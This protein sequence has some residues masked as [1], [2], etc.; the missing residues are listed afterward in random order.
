MKHELF[1]ETQELFNQA[2]GNSG[3]VTSI[4]PGVAS[5]VEGGG[6]VAFNHK[7]VNLLVVYDVD[8]ISEPTKIYH[9]SNVKTNLL[10]IVVDKTSIK[11]TSVTNTY[12]FTRTGKHRILFR[13]TSLS[14]IPVSAFTSCSTIISF[15]LPKQTTKIQNYAFSG[16]IKIG[17]NLKIQDFVTNIGQYAFNSCT[18]IRK[19]DVPC[20]STTIENRGFYQCRYLHEVFV[21]TDVLAGVFSRT[22]DGFG[23]LHV[24]GSLT[25][26]VGSATDNV[27][28]D[29]NKIIID[30]DLSNAGSYHYSTSDNMEVLKVGGNYSHTAGNPPFLYTY[31]QAQYRDG[32][33]HLTFIEVMGTI[34]GLVNPNYNG[35]STIGANWILH[36]GY[37]G[38]AGTPNDA[39]VTGG[40]GRRLYKVYVGDGSSEEHDQEIL[41]QY[42][43][44]DA[45][46]AYASK[47]DIWYNYHGEYRQE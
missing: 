41:N 40:N 30:G 13:Y 33:S 36:L 8:D 24:G 22:G 20:S 38:I 32:Q 12:Q 34:T 27:G 37:D 17:P 19:L 15:K 35:A 21:N 46:S 47:L 31:N 44:D 14:E 43:A 26:P 25:R 11:A 10:E 4:T 6:A 9:S 42:L 29:Y 45:W 16:C 18:G 5:I 7:I 1:Y 23:T 28:C 3:N 39:T 2:Q